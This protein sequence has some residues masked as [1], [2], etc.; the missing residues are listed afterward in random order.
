MDKD[1]LRKAAF[2]A[3]YEANKLN[4]GDDMAQHAREIERW[5]T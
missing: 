4:K 1:K 5:S 3:Y 2:I